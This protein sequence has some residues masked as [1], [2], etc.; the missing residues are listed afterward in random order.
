VDTG[1]TAEDIVVT[2]GGYSATAAA[3]FGKDR[4]RADRSA[5]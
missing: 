5:S 1:L 4:Q 2:Y 3:L